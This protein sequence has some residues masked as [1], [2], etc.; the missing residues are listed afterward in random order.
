ML[1]K[2]FLIGR[3]GKDPEV[4]K[5]ESGASVA[6]FSIATDES[7]KDKAGNKVEQ[8]AWHNV[9]VWGKLAE[10]AEKYLKKGMLI[11]L[12]GKM[13]YREYTDKENIKRTFAEVVCESFKMLE[14]SDSQQNGQAPG[15]T[16]EN[17]P[18]GQ[19]PEQA[20]DAPSGDLPF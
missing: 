13:S 18:Q 20:E 17:A 1:N 8:T 2:I 4:R 12:E 16:Q 11:H 19:E 7:Y 14:R 10:V 9:V 6:K 15:R 3:L 5:L